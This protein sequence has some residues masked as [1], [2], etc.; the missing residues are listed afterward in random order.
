MEERL[1]AHRGATILVLGILS[2][3]LCPIVLGIMAWVMGN[4]D[5]REMDAG[6]MDPSGRGL[7]E[8][9]RILGM[10]NVILGVV[11]L[12]FYLLVF[13]LMVAGNHR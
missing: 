6:R 12:V 9:G 13:G 11:G 1:A 3:L 2:W 4:G 7:T 8:A 5:L 10:I